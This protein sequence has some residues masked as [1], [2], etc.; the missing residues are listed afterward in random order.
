MGQDKTASTERLF[1]AACIAIL[2]T[3]LAVSQL[4]A[5]GQ[6]WILATDDTR[7]T[8]ALDAEGRPIITELVNP[9]RAFNWALQP[10]PIP[11]P[12]G[13]LQDGRAVAG[14]WTLRNAAV[15]TS[16]GTKLTLTFSNTSGLEFQSEW[17]ARPG[18]GP[19]HHASLITNNSGAAM[20]IEY[21]PTL[22][23]Q[24][25]AP[26]SDRIDAWHFKT[27]GGHQMVDPQGVYRE[28]IASGFNR[29]VRTNPDGPA[30]AAIP[31]AVIDSG[32][33][34]GVY[35]GTEWSY[36]DIEI[37]GS[38]NG[39]TVK[40]GNVLGFQT[41]LQAGQAFEV[42][43]GFVGAYDGDI[44]TAGNRLRKYL[45]RNS[46]P[47][48]VR[49]GSGYPKVQWN[50]FGA[51]GKTPGGWDPVGSKYFP[52]V[53][54]MASLGFEE[55]MIDVGWWSGNEP[56]TDAQDWPAGMKAA[57]DYAKQRGMKFGLYW[58]D[59]A[60]MATE[61]GRKTRAD[62][63]KRL[64]QEYGADL[65]RSDNT[66][67]PLI[68]PNYES[69][70]GFYA[71]VDRLAQDVPGFQWENCSSGGRIKDYG[72]MQRSVKIFNSDTYS[73]LDVRKVFYDS[74]FALHPLQLEG[75]LGSTDGSLRPVGAAGMKY[76]FRSMSM[77]APEW[78]L[79]APNGGNG[80]APWTAEEREAVKSCVTTYKDRIRPLVRNADLYH[81]FPRPD[82]RAWDGIEYYDPAVRKG[83]VFIFKPDA[84]DDTHTIVLKGLDPNLMYHLTFEDGSNA[85]AHLL[86]AVLM[87]S[88]IDVTLR[89]R[90]VSELMF[91]QVAEPNSM[92]LLTVGGL[93]LAGFL[94]RRRLAESGERSP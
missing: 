40:S 39:V 81:I 90:N 21:Q 61:A 58:T 22:S 66:H 4:A 94:W 93:A 53:D 91:I 62:R 42:P 1:R 75:H 71:M 50:A 13:V 46:M 5:A 49:M 30:G 27:D 80:S 87:N 89:G 72:A 18:A 55:V 7:M 92:T 70:K 10:N 69:V 77:G 63:I 38:A 79:D 15:D 29:V 37:A 26:Q 47:E 24:L 14:N 17:W 8:I 56:T 44:D 52:L 54:D 76:A 83:V 45:L 20:G 2:L 65:W 86:G 31:L 67:G 48:S 51:T 43:P 57:A 25:N 88:G 59:N 33:R 74:S 19:I 84:S 85:P 16:D 11:L 28:P 9:S 68:T 73:E 41:T 36:G 64:Y 35:V 34:Q 78:F 6:S 60:D 32:G 82:G 3:A 12:T 23:L